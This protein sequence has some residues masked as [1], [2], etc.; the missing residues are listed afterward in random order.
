MGALVRG[1][2]AAIAQERYNGDLARAWMAVDVIV[3]AD[4]SAS[5][6]E[7]V[8]GRPAIHYARSAIE[9]IQHEHPGRV[10]IIAY[11]D[12]AT[13][14]PHGALPE[15]CGNTRLAPALELAR[16]VAALG[17]RIV[18][19]S[20]GLWQDHSEALKLA[21]ALGMQRQL[22]GIYV[23]G[24]RAGQRAL[25][26]ICRGRGQTMTRRMPELPAAIRGLLAGS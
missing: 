8:D 9:G 18:I 25:E 6:R 19:I 2:V 10:A 1:S 13:L 16:R 3:L 11:N 23:G 14:L 21:M 7:L 26:E 20:D 4:V 15:P 12:V 24:D 17:V 22:D 5:M